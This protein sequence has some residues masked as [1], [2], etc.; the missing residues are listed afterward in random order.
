MCLLIIVVPNITTTHGETTLEV[1]NMLAIT[2]V[3]EGFP[4]PIVSWTHNGMLVPTCTME[5]FEMQ[6][7]C[8]EF[9][10]V[11]DSSSSLLIFSAKLSDTGP[12][13]CIAENS[14]GVASYEVFVT[15]ERATS[16][17]MYI[18]TSLVECDIL[19]PLSS[20]SGLPSF[21]VYPAPVTAV[22][23]SL[24]TLD[25]LVR[26]D[27]APTVSWLKDFTAVNLTSGNI[28]IEPNGTLVI[29]EAGLEDAGF[30]T[31]VANNEVGINQVSVPVE[32][33]SEVIINKTGL[34]IFMLH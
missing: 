2:C 16:T 11:R 5:L 31:C 4:P 32:V 29:M 15:V 1:G 7:L 17:Y 6:I 24:I 34:S 26:G 3:A 14:A 18:C 13:V 30:Y 19:F 21:L 33:I 28:V 25:C 27:P 23:G 10:P 8:A 9:R 12:Y 22:N 20:L